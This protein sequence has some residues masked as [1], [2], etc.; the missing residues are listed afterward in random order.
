MPKWT[1]SPRTGSGLRRT[2]M[3]EEGKEKEKR[4][5]KLKGQLMKTETVKAVNF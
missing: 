2:D 4:W 5:Q 1:M 3:V